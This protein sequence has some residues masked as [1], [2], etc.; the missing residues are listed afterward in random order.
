M[1]NTLSRRE[2]L[3]VGTK[4]AIGTLTGLSIFPTIVSANALGRSIR[5][6]NVWS[7][8]PGKIYDNRPTGV[9]TDFETT[10]I[11]GFSL[12]HADQIRLNNCRVRWAENS[13]EYFTHAVKAENVNALKITGFKG[14][15]AQP[16]LY[17]S[18][19]IY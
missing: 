1:Q 13:P 4:F 17:D 11:S 16:E 7:D 19:A 12:R 8:Q 9:Y 18:I 5:K 3:K 15:S 6:F 14:D 2:A 10:D